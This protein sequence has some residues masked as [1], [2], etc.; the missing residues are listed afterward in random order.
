MVSLSLS[1]PSGYSDW[2]ERTLHS[3]TGP[4][5]LRMHAIIHC[6]TPFA[7][8]CIYTGI[9]VRYTQLR[10][11]SFNTSFNKPMKYKL[12]HTYVDKGSRGHPEDQFLAW[13][14]IDGSGMLNSPGIR[15]LRYTSALHCDDLPA[16]LV[17]VTH[18]VTGG[19][20]NPWDDVIDM[21]NAEILYWGDAK[22]D[23]KKQIDDFKG[24]SVLRRIFD[25]ILGGEKALVPPI[26]HF[27]KP[28]KGYVKFNGLCVM[29]KLDI[30]WFDDHGS[31][32]S[33]YHAKLTIL[34]CEE[35]DLEWLHH[36]AVSECV[37]KIDDH[38]ACPEA[39]S[40]YKKGYKKPI[41]IWMKQVRTQAQQLPPLASQEDEILTQLVRLDPYDF[42]RVIVSIFQQMTDITHHVSGTRAT[43][44]GGFDFY[45]SF[46]L[47]RPL[48]YE[49]SF[50]GE[51][52]RYSRATAVDPKSVSRLVARLTRAE[53]G[54]F[55]TTSYFTKQAQ[56]EVLA[57]GYPIHLI[58]GADL[59]LMLKH[60]RLLSEGK[61]RR[62]WLES[63]GV[64]MS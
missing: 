39:W 50:R 52:K 22:A 32:V 19:Q 37:P 1:E 60:L 3:W 16:Y 20:S 58:T 40:K 12:G 59:V 8:I 62:D 36:R 11:L 42:E 55:V 57:D 33:N 13:V 4:C 27:S 25:Y 38:S 43:A 41:D 29:D 46:K 2:L 49:I 35:V 53:Y 17:L 34:D 10:L 56:R 6:F 54:I 47:P 48:G 15:P 18:D 7:F 31:P 26:L 44:D 51:V 30:S 14:N 61:V 24:N 28:K 63:I 64:N 45:G 9:L 23:T 5:A 21:S